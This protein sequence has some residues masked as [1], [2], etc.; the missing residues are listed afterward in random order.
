MVAARRAV[1]GAVAPRARAV[2]LRAAARAGRRHRAPAP[3]ARAAAPRRA[4]RAGVALRALR[5]AGPA[6]PAPSATATGR[7]TA[8]RTAGRPRG[9]AASTRAPAP[10]SAAI[11]NSIRAR[12]SASGRGRVT[13]RGSRCSIRCWAV[14][15]R[16][17]TAFRDARRRAQPV[18]PRN[19]VQSMPSFLILPR[20]V[21]GLSPSRSAAPPRPSIRPDVSESA[22]LMLQRL[23]VRSGRGRPCGS[24]VDRAPGPVHPNDELL[25]PSVPG[26]CLPGAGD[27]VQG[28]GGERAVDEP[29]EHP[30]RLLLGR[31][32]RSKPAAR[33][34]LRQ[35]RGPGGRR[36]SGQDP[37]S[38]VLRPDVRVPAGLQPDAQGQAER[39]QGAV[40]PVH[41]RKFLRDSRR[42][43]DTRTLHFKDRGGSGPINAWTAPSDPGLV[44]LW[45]V[46]RDDRGGVGWAE[47]LIQVDP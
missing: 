47:Y 42:V 3:A 19:V 10:R 1:A 33:V 9:H 24:A 34:R 39:P 35:R 29:A 23:R 18:R 11:T 7:A 22:R 38:P 27:R 15:P 30:G 14:A 8:S 12:A 41:A 5:A 32:D 6:A 25:R 40:L 36:Q 16:P 4:A 17:S 46:L 2:R 37:G 21:C 31:D 26:R 45:V 20:N 28:P 44:R 43:S 13:R